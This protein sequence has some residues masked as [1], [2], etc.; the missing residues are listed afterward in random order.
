MKSYD[1][2][3]RKG[4]EDAKGRWHEPYVVLIEKL[5]R[6]FPVEEMGNLLD[7]EKQKDFVRLLGE[8]LRVRNVLSVFDAFDEGARLVSDMDYQD[9]KGWYYTFYEKSATPSSM[10]RTLPTTSYSR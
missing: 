1:E 6:E 3:Y 5:L 7:E 8:I 10:M 2:Y 4:Y 9:Y